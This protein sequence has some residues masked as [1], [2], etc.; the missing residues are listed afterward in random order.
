MAEEKSD[1]EA[2]VE[3]H[4]GSSDPSH[5]GDPFG[6]GEG[7]LDLTDHGLSELGPEEQADKSATEAPAE[8]EFEFEDGE[9]IT[10]FLGGEMDA[11]GYELASEDLPPEMVANAVYE[12]QD[13]GYSDDEIEGALAEAG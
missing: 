10:A 6:G 2:M 3:A 5:R 12:L 9:D 1:V 7:G 4:G 13:A 8:P 11:D